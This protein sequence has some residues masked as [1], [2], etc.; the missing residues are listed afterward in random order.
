MEALVD[1]GLVKAIGLSNFNREQVQRVVAGAR[2]K[3]AANQVTR[4]KH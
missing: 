4:F 1:A 2:I 3:P